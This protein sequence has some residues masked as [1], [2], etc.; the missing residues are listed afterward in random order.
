[1]VLE[2][3]VEEAEKEVRI[4]DCKDN[5]TNINEIMLNDDFSSFCESLLDLTNSNE[6]D[7]MDD[8]SVNCIELL[9]TDAGIKK[10][11]GYLDEVYYNLLC[12]ELCVHGSSFAIINII[13]IILLVIS[14]QLIFFV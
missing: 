11:K 6:D 12:L 10:A 9:Y 5:A 3:G 1:M 8:A 7:K 2:A 14:I 4:K 13:N